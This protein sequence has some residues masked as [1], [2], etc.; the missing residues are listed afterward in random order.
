MFL[1]TILM[2]PLSNALTLIVF[3]AIVFRSGPLVP[4]FGSQSE[5][6]ERATSA[7]PL[8]AKLSVR[9]VRRVRREEPELYVVLFSRSL[10]HGI[11]STRA[12]RARTSCILFVLHVV[13]CVGPDHNREG[14]VTVADSRHWGYL[15]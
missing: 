4:M 2:F 15:D 3:R 8:H 14:Y 11:A 13:N 1:V 10:D 5:K 12:D 7:Q 9:K 6:V